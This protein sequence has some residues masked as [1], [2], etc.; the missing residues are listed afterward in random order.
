[1]EKTYRDI[2]KWGEFGKEEELNPHVIE[3]LQKALNVDVSKKQKQGNAIVQLDKPCSLSPEVI[4]QFASICGAENVS[5]TDVDRAKHGIGRFYLDSLKARDCVIDYPPD[6]VLYPRN[7]TEIVNILAICEELDIAV[8]PVGARSSVTRA[9]EATRGG[10]SLDLTKHFKRILKFSEINS[11]VTVEA[12]IMGPV[13]ENF[14]N[15]NGYT[16]GHFPQSFEFSTPGGWVAARGAGQASTGYGKAEDMLLSLR[17]VSPKGVLVTKDYPTES[18]GPEL[19]R[20]LAGSEGIFGA[21]TQVTLKIRK[22]NPENSAKSSF[23]FRDFENAV[24]A[25]RD[26]MHGQFGFPH[27]FRLQDPEETE[28]SF[29]MAGM[30]GGV[31]DMF[32]KLLGYNPNNRSLMHVIVEGDRD[33]TRLVMRKVAQVAMRYGAFETGKKPVDKW[34][35]QRYSSAYLREPFMDIGVRLDTIET[36]VSWENL[37]HLWSSVRT[38]IK[39]RQNTFCLVH[40]SHCYENGANLYFIFL[41]KMDTDNE[42][43]SF[44]TFHKGIIES[45]HKNGGSLSHHHGIG[46]M[47]RPW[48]ESEI[49]SIGKGMISAV[50]NYLDPKG[51]M[52]PDTIV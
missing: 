26:V 35:A 25:M 7:E 28:L 30:S 15:K 18:T 12:G 33:Y 37:I 34:L 8:I 3:F 14:L 20:F 22:Y 38:Y 49:G 47:L 40:I 4:E 2:F 11:S 45:I 24:A 27:F 36:S 50:K 29:Q 46:K 32:L 19:D 10:V 43:Q 23:I 48:L 44:T 13:L 52:N 41:S 1:V 9:L 39:S 17:M 16:C 21:I 51:I 42:I 5:T 31:E 6:A